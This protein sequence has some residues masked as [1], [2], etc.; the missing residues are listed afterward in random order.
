MATAGGV[1]VGNGGPWAAVMKQEYPSGSQARV[2][3]RC[4]RS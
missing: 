4:L 2:P 3:S 1:A